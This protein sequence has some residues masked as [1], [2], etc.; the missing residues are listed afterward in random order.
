MASNTYGI[1]L[2][3]VLMTRARK[4]IIDKSTVANSK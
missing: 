4:T 3:S 2:S 1:L